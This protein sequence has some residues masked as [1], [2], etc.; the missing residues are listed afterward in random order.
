MP[1]QQGYRIPTKSKG[2]KF[3]N[4]YNDFVPTPFGSGNCAMP[5]FECT[6]D[7]NKIIPDEFVCE[8]NDKCPAYEPEL[9]KICP[10]HDV[11]YYFKEWCELCYPHSED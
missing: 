10:K 7:G 6:Y 3:G 9:T 11:E 4:H 2:C 5:G 8:E 1:I